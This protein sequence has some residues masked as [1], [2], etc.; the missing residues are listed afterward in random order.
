M[1]GSCLGRV[2][3]LVIVMSSVKDWLLRTHCL[4]H[5]LPTGTRGEHALPSSSCE[6]RC[7][8]VCSCD[9]WLG[10]QFGCWL[11]GCPTLDFP[12]SFLVCRPI[13]SEGYE[14][15]SSFVWEWRVAPG[16]PS[17]AC[18]ISSGTV[19]KPL[20]PSSV[21]KCLVI[22]RTQILFGCGRQSL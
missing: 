10:S 4:P 8:Q 16:H 22:I 3:E 6:L 5:L 1:C 9:R 21:T 12:L 14:T 2:A 20:S 11:L 19:R 7:V 13:A 15:P 18:K 17:V